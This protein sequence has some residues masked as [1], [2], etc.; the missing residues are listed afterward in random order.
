MLIN[1]VVSILFIFQKIQRH[2]NTFILFLL[3]VTYKGA[4]KYHSNILLLNKRNNLWGGEFFLEA[5]YMLKLNQ[6]ET[7]I[8]NNNSGTTMH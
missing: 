4:E 8:T 2:L 1:Y 3:R 5:L 7:N 6:N